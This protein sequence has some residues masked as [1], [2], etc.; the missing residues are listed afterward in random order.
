MN[1]KIVTEK[2]K[3]IKQKNCG[4]VL[5]VAVASNVFTLKHI[6]VRKKHTHVD[7][8]RVVSYTLL[9]EYSSATTYK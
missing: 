6:I 4:S 2:E 5:Q 8:Q 3:A 7:F 1:Q 9:T